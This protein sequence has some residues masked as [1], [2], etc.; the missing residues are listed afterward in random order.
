M[1]LRPG[2]KDLPKAQAITLI[3]NTCIRYR[4]PYNH[5]APMLGFD[6]R[7][8]PNVIEKKTAKPTPK[9][10]IPTAPKKESCSNATEKL[11][12]KKITFSQKTKIKKPS[13]KDLFADNSE[14]IRFYGML[15]YLKSCGVGLH[16]EFTSLPKEKRYQWIKENKDKV[17]K[18][19]ANKH[20][21]PVILR[22][23]KDEPVE[24][25]E[26]LKPIPGYPNYHI[27]NLGN[28]YSDVWG[29]RKLVAR[30]KH[31]DGRYSVMLWHNNKRKC[32][33]IHR[34]MAEYWMTK[35]DGLTDVFFHNDDKSDCR[36]ENLYFAKQ[37]PN[38]PTWNP[39]TKSK[40]ETLSWWNKLKEREVVDIYLSSESHDRLA[41]QYG[42]SRSL[43]SLIKN[44]K[45]WKWLTKIYQINNVAV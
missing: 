30:R 26:Q 29:K 32:F 15:H 20:K 27:S 22:P 19:S 1:E 40:G 39:A 10:I 8:E 38:K 41:I 45:R 4:L 25:P 13:I 33:Y 43:I 42:V 9:S 31:R 24:G 17:L 18:Y 37:P 23:S 2:I 28:V 16:S 34:L 21:S 6:L 44:D 14:R 35:V 7:D 11:E 12:R 36:L 5:I 3:E